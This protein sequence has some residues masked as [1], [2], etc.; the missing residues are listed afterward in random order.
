MTFIIIT[1]IFIIII[2]IAKGAWKVP[3]SAPVYLRD[4]H[5]PGAPLTTHAREQQEA[6]LRAPAKLR[7]D[8]PCP[9]RARIDQKNRDWRT[10]KVLWDKEVPKLT[11][12]T[13]VRRDKSNQK[14]FASYE[15]RARTSSGLPGGYR[16]ALNAK[17]S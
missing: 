17:A 1:T 11:C 10:W 4:V 14:R 6:H 12:E 5:L 9:H 13:S 3:T 8:P 16:E 2:I 7:L 15:M